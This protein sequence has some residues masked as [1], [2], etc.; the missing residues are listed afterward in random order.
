MSK[1]T[2]PMLCVKAFFWTRHD[3]HSVPVFHSV[4][5]EFIV[6]QADEVE[7]TETCSTTQQ[8]TNMKNLH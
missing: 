1:I 3:G 5:H 4:E 8:I 7:T 6:E 2:R